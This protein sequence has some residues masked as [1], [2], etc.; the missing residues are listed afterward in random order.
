MILFILRSLVMMS[1]RPYFRR[2]HLLVCRSRRP[3]R[4][5]PMRDTQCPA[6]SLWGR[7]GAQSRSSES[8]RSSGSRSGVA[9]S[10]SLGS[11]NSW[12]TK[13]VAKDPTSSPDC[14]RSS[15]WSH[16]R[17]CC[18]WHIPFMSTLAHD[19][20][21]TILRTRELCCKVRRPWTTVYPY[22]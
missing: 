11:C 8:S 5:S 13:R 7:R 19:S 18:H 22:R 14:V 15:W 17:G 16:A 4:D 21:W 12:L 1:D 6:H 20:P 9:R 10:K 2:H 3:A